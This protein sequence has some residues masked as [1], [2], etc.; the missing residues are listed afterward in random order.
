MRTKAKDYYHVLEDGTQG[1][2]GY[3]NC[4]KTL[5]EAQKEVERLSDFWPDIHFWI[6]HSNSPKE[7]VIVTN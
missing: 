2:I 6:F 5:E 1:D 7:P 3:Q 4:Y